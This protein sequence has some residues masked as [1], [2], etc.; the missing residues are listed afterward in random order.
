MIFERYQNFEQCLH[1]SV[2]KLSTSVSNFTWRDSIAL[3]IEIIKSD[4]QSLY[5]RELL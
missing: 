4:Q 2:M 5:S 3:H 1:Y